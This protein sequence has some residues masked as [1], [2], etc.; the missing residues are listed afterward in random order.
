MKLL[1]PAV[2]KSN[3]QC[4]SENARQ[5]R[6]DWHRPT[7]MKPSSTQKAYSIAAFFLQTPRT[8]LICLGSVQWAFRM[9][10]ALSKIGQ[11]IMQHGGLEPQITGKPLSN[12]QVESFFLLLPCLLLPNSLL[13]ISLFPLPRLAMQLEFLFSKAFHWPKP[14]FPWISHQA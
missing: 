1:P 7:N 3:N 4:L 6:E 9:Y 11:P 10:K 13:Q 12:S 2:L 8:V 5:D 14:P